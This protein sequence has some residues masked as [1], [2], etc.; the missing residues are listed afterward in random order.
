MIR[1]PFKYTYLAKLHGMSLNKAKH[2]Q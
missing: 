2:D 1:K